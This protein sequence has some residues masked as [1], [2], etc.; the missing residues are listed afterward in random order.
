MCTQHTHIVINRITDLECEYD[1]HVFVY[2]MRCNIFGRKVLA[3]VKLT[4]MDLLAR[5]NSSDWLIL[6][7]R[8]CALMYDARNWVW[9]GRM[10]IAL[11]WSIWSKWSGEDRRNYLMI[12]TPT[13]FRIQIPVDCIHWHSWLGY[14]R[15]LRRNSQWNSNVENA[16]ATTTRE[17][18]T[19]VCHEQIQSFISIMDHSTNPHTHTDADSKWTFV[20]LWFLAH[21]ISKSF[22]LYQF[23]NNH[24][25]TATL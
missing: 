15:V 16:A 5:R 23:A 17:M 14:W 6:F 4:K 3:Q 22:H 8:L 1:E 25:F 13:L 20:C 21:C 12:S 19:R 10:W 24:A 9:V 11:W 18:A 2:E 7:I